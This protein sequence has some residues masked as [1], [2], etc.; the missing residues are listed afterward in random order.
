M[1]KDSK[2]SNKIKQAFLN[3][4]LFVGISIINNTDKRFYWEKFP[5]H[6][7]CFNA[8][9]ISAKYGKIWWGD[10]DLTLDG[11]KIEKVARELNEDL[12]VL[13]ELDAR[14]ENEQLTGSQLKEKAIWSTR[15]FN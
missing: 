11:M 4:K 15:I 9:I 5:D 1:E 6:L 12:Y 10:L 7:V 14:F 3:A 8:N 13:R 2:I